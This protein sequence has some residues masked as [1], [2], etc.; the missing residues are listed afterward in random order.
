M[1]E[2][3][4]DSYRSET[5]PRYHARD[6]ARFRCHQNQAALVL[7]SATPDLGSRWRA[8]T[9]EY[10]FF[11]LHERYN[12]KPLP[13]VH[14]VDMKQELRS[15][16]GSLLSV[17]LREAIL[18]RIERGEQSILFLNRRGSSKVVACSVCG[19][20]YRYAAGAFASSAREPRWPRRNCAGLSRTPGF[21][22]L[23]PIP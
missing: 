2:E 16:N 18:Q 4:E 9:G 8:E 1:D 11:R 6:I 17:P 5:N 10:G 19:Y 12:L 7:G 23:T 15:G 20:T 14:L 3:Q 22:A 21:C 13:A